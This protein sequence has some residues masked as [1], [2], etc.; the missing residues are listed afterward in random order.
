MR[1]RRI[2]DFAASSLLLHGA[3]CDLSDLPA[4]PVDWLSDITT[5]HDALIRYAVGLRPGYERLGRIVGQIAG[6][7]ILA[8][9]GRRFEA[10][11]PMAAIVVEQA[12]VVEDELHGVWVP[13]AARQHHRYLLQ[14]LERV[15]KVVRAF[16]HCLPTGDPLRE[17]LDAWTRELKLA[18]AMLSGAAVESLGLMPLDF[19]QACCNCGTK[20]PMNKS[21]L[22]YV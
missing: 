17:Q 21:D 15:Q 1:I 7:L 12:A 3:D 6:M 5:D 20:P 16:G 14:A 8:R 4:A 19:S 9:L 10:D 22:S 13:A 2:S 18:G 11:W